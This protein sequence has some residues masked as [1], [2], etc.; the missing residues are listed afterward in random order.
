MALRQQDMW[1]TTLMVVSSDNGGTWEGSNNYDVNLP[2]QGYKA[3]NYEGGVRVAAFVSGGYLPS[4]MRGK[5]TDA[6]MHISDWYATFCFLAGVEATDE[7]AEAAELPAVTSVDQWPL[8]SGQA[9]E[10]ARTELWLDYD[11]LYMYREANDEHRSSLFKYVASSKL[12]ALASSSDELRDVLRDPGEEIDFFSIYPRLQATM[13]TRLKDELRPTQFTRASYTGD[14]R[15]D[16]K[17][18]SKDFIADAPGIK[19]ACQATGVFTPAGYG[20]PPS[21]PPPSPPR[22]PPPPSPP[23]TPLFPRSPPMPPPPA[24][25]LLNS[26]AVPFYMMLGVFIGAFAVVVRSVFVT[27]RM[28]G[29]RSGM[30]TLEDESTSMART[31]REHQVVELRQAMDP[32]GHMGFVA[33]RSP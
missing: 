30:S 33:V 10:P 5:S 6:L 1:D 15:D 31:P 25:P 24:A 3:S 9:T 29:R 28:F 4:K 13:E 14:S 20:S 18:T 8:L 2:L 27:A 17:L 21:P 26:G 23:H 32:S 12:A 16:Q 19:A 7:R 11:V 22:P